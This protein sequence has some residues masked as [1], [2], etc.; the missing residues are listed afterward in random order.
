[1]RWTPSFH[2]SDCTWRDPPPS[3]LAG[4]SGLL[5]LPA[6]HTT[7]QPCTHRTAPDC[8]HT[9]ATILRNAHPQDDPATTPEA[10]CRVVVG[11]VLEPKVQPPP[12]S[13][14]SNATTAGQTPAARWR[15]SGWR[16]SFWVC[17]TRAPMG[18]GG[19]ADA[20]FEKH[21]RSIRHAF[22]DVAGYNQTFN[23]QNSVLSPPATDLTCAVPPQQP[24]PHQNRRNP[25]LARAPLGF[26]NLAMAAQV[27]GRDHGQ[28][29]PVAGA[30]QVGGRPGPRVNTPGHR[31]PAAG[32]LCPHGRLRARVSLEAQGPCCCPPPPSL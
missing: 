25:S 1:M 23:Q 32:G 31:L 20:E 29:V 22:E 19:G 2:S 24:R 8:T 6:K 26:P 9:A 14:W 11:L 7:A 28:V 4:S 18:Q 3:P 10:E 17:I 16:L 5:P 12:P 21:S 27:R 15:T 30:D 13:P